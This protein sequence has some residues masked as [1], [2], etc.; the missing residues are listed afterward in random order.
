MIVIQI[1]II[2]FLVFIWVVVYQDERR[3]RK[4]QRN[5]AKLNSFWNKNK[6]IKERRK[7]VRITA[8]LNVSYEL[9]RDNAAQ[10]Y[11]SMTRNVGLGGMNLLLS[12]KLFLGTTLHFE[13]NIPQS[14]RPIFIEGK[15]IWVR[16]FSGKLARQKRERFF[17]TGIQFIHIKPQDEAILHDFIE[18][19]AKNAP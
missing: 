16:E 14:H 12:E 4:L 10:R 2:I 11:N 6:A 5:S 8:D 13:L 17:A 1:S 7:S 15:I 18:Q 3:K 19:K 9:L